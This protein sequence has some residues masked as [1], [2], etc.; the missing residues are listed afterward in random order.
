ML[1]IIA[2]VFVMFAVTK[3]SSF[4]ACMCENIVHC[5]IITFHVTNPEA[6]SEQLRI[7]T[8][9]LLRVH[10]RSTLIQGH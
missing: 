3:K 9:H 1:L 2:F 5:E 8:V 7:N 4:I 10:I 6:L